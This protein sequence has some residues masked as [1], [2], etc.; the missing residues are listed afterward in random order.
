MNEYE[1]LLSY[2]DKQDRPGFKPKKQVDRV[3]KS[4]EDISEKE[5]KKPEVSSTKKLI[6]ECQ[7][8]KKSIDTPQ[9]TEVS[10][11]GFDVEKFENMMRTRLIDDY[12]KMQSY[13]RPNISVTELLYCM[14]K[15]YYS[16]LKYATDLKKQFNFAYLDI[17]NRIGNTVHDYVQ[18]I[19]NFAEVEKTIVSEKYKVKGRCDAIT[20]PFL[21]EFKTLD[22]VKFTGLYVKEHY[23]QPI[24]YSYI[25]NT[26]YNY[27][28]KTITLVYFFRDNIK[29]KPYTIDLPL[30]DK[31]AIGFL[32]QA[33][34]LQNCLVSKIV[35]DPFNANQE[36][37][38]WCP[39]ISYC[40]NDA[41]SIGRPFDVKKKVKKEKE[42]DIF[43]DTETKPK[44]KKEAIFVL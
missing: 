43:K 5:E 7:E 22:E 40:E 16:R 20:Q 42:V 14:R 30:D 19:Y 31:I 25:L 3:V 4:F 37:C 26:E 44:E 33:V 36:Q 29:R 1:Q 9:L 11:I 15:S 27:N 6:E 10:S 8:K 2:L 32:E 13:E 34:T 41:S 38:R 35:P 12:K 28:I 17:I 39:Y 18:E 23:Y 21:Y 24:I